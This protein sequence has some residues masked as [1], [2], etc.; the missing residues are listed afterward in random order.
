[1]PNS[2]R[3]NDLLH[4]ARAYVEIVDELLGVREG[5]KGII[6]ARHYQH[7]LA[8]ERV[9][10]VFRRIWS[11]SG[12]VLLDVLAET[13]GVV[14]RGESDTGVFCS[15]GDEFR[16]VGARD[17]RNSKADPGLYRQWSLVF[18]EYE[19]AATNRGVA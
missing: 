14:R 2:R 4:T 16:V 19:G 12:I 17:D 13:V 9:R 5:N 18:R 6:S 1:M 15:S 7:F 10:G 8:Q 11:A 3:H